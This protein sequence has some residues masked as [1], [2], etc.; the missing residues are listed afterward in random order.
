MPVG[1]AD[2]QFSILQSVAPS[3][4]VQFAVFQSFNLLHRRLSLCKKNLGGSARERENGLDFSWVSL[5]G[6]PPLLIS[7]ADKPSGIL[8]RGEKV[9]TV[10]LM[11]DYNIR[12]ET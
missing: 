1:M 11:V 6:A 12:V 9:A 7:K 5:M 3:S 4:D 2:V 10:L 8:K